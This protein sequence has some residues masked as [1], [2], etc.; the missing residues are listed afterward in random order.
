[1][2]G[3]DTP[4]RFNLPLIALHWLTLIVLA[5]AYATSELREVFPKGSAGRESM[6]N[7]HVLLGLIVFGIAWL[8]LLVRMFSAIPAVRPAPPPWQERLAKLAHVALYG[9]MLL[10][11]LTGWLMLSADGKPVDLLGWQLPA[12]I[13]PNRSIADGL[14]DVHEA[15]AS[16]GYALIGL[17]AAAALS[18]H[19]VLRDN[20]LRLMLPTFRRA[21]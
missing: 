21:S 17:H 13:T 8:R 14:E 7:L 20:A 3:I 5:L 12:L 2:V 16:A 15:L 9:L 18:H 10:L 19:Y 6:M 4:P 11:P 1:M